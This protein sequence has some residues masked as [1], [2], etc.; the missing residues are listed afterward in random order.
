[1]DDF[2]QKQVERA[3]G[4]VAMAA[5]A[6][7]TGDRGDV[8]VAS[9]PQA[10]PDLVR[11]GLPKNGGDLDRLDRKQL[12]DEAFGVFIARLGPFEIIEAER[13]PA[14][15]AVALENELVEQG[16]QELGA[17]KRLALED[18]FADPV[19][20]AAL[21]DEEPG[22]VERFGRGVAKAEA[23]GVGDDAGEQTGGDFGRNL[24]PQ[25]EEEAGQDEGGGG[26]GGVDDPQVAG[27]L[28]GDV[29][30][31]DD[32]PV[33]ALEERS[34]TAQALGAVQIDD[35]AE[36]VF[37][38]FGLLADALGAG[39]EPKVHRR[40]VVAEDLVV[41]AQAIESERDRQSRAQGVS[42][43]V[44][45]RS[46]DDG[47]RIFDLPPKGEGVFVRLAQ[48]EF[49]GLGRERR[50]ER[51]DTFDLAMAKLGARIPGILGSQGALD[52]FW[53]AVSGW[54]VA[55]WKGGGFTGITGIIVIWRN[56]LSSWSC[57]HTVICRRT[58]AHAIGR[59]ISRSFVP[60]LFRSLPSGL[61]GGF[62]QPGR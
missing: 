16:S 21:F 34:R 60:P 28:V 30:V 46:D 19:D 35:D 1:M 26:G 38:S 33:A 48:N 17:G 49:G 18:L 27:G 61:G 11:L 56:S 36:V 51:Q 58:L 31:D 50:L 10:H 37:R 12:V 29:M 5:A 39:K 14:K 7:F 22:E 20:V 15:A 53:L 25:L 43:R 54:Q 62:G 4:R 45:V 59:P 8:E 55:V 24:E 44:E 40:N 2:I 47:G 42:V 3:A 6:E 13:A 32:D 23:A 41:H 57:H 52:M 9:R